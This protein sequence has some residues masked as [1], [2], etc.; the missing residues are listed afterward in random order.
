RVEADVLDEV[1]RLL[2]G[3][4]VEA[5]H[6]S[7]CA[8]HPHGAADQEAIARLGVRQRAERAMGDLHGLGLAEG[9]RR[10]NAYGTPEA[11]KRRPRRSLWDLMPQH[12][13]ERAAVNSPYIVFKK[14]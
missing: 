8:V 9:H 12:L 11:E 6:D 1:V 10:V 2:E 14:Q 13:R 5:A 3:P 7:D 4:A